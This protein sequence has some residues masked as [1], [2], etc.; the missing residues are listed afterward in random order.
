VSWYETGKPLTETAR[1]MP[2][3]ESYG[4][5]QNVIFAMTELPGGD[6]LRSRIVHPLLMSG[7]AVVW[8]NYEASLD[9]AQLEPR[10]RA[11]STYVLQEY[12]IPV[13][14]FVEYAREMAR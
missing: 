5:H 1:L 13:C 10:T 3:D 6:V 9:V 11:I 4:L 7:R 2:Q 12:F 8:R 14:H